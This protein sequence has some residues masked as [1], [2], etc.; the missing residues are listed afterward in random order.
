MRILARPLEFMRGLALVAAALLALAPSVSRLLPDAM[1]APAGTEAMCTTEGLQARV[2]VFGEDAPA[3][4]RNHQECGYCALLASA[5]PLPPALAMDVPTVA[6][7]AATLRL[8]GAQ[9]GG[10]SSRYVD[11]A[12]AVR[13]L[14]RRPQ[15]RIQQQ[16]ELELIGRGSDFAAADLLRAGPVRRVGTRGGLNAS[17]GGDPEIE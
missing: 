6:A 13:R 12:R 16:T 17:Q 11:L 1:A 2:P 10:A 14:R 5:L 15:Q 7:G 3:L 9:L 8:D 4:P